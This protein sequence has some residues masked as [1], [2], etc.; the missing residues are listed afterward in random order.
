MKGDQVGPTRPAMAASAVAFLAIVCA[1]A[2]CARGGNPSVTDAHHS[3]PITSTQMTFHLEVSAT[4]RPVGGPFELRVVPLLEYPGG[5]SLITF[6]CR[7]LGD[8]IESPNKLLLKSS[9]TGSASSE[10]YFD[11]LPARQSSQP[12]RL[13]PIDSFIKSHTFECVAKEPGLFMIQATLYVRDEDN[14]RTIVESEPI[15]V[16]ATAKEGK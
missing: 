7:K 5:V 14:Q 1:I 12:R 2:G 6:S 8:G 9:S 4:N 13:S 3:D 11:G 16:L 15:V 10:L